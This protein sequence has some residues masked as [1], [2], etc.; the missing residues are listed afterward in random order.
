MTGARDAGLFVLLSALWGVA[1]VVIK[2][3]L[4]VLPPVLFAAFRYD[5]AGAVMLG[6]VAF[7]GDW[8]LRSRADYL[9][10][11]VGSTL[12]IGFYNALLFVGQSGVTS[13]VASILIAT[14]PILAAVFSRAL[15]GERL[16]A[17][18]AV[19][20]GLG[21]VGVGLVAAP[22]TLAVRELLSP[23]L[24]LA[25]AASVAL[26]SVLIQRLDAGIATEGLVAWSNALGAV[27][28]HAVSAALG[29]PVP[30][31]IT[32]EAVAAV[33]YLAVLASAA[34]YIVY[35]DLLDRLGAVEI[36][37]VSYAAPVFAV[38]VGWLALGE[39]IGPSTVVGFLA[40]FAG[41]AL[42][43]RRAFRERLPGVE[44]V[45]GSQTE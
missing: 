9:A 10:V 2:A 37:L 44:V 8:R 42:V 17:L 12:V 18:G 35:F 13:G 14:N 1:F 30:A 24:L 6:Y 4:A 20:L 28:L 21:L 32:A 5:V 34:G 38:V 29:E 7:T 23:A 3:G 25:A 22:E 39:R 16:S 26:G 33:A 41:F 19:G 11:L 31:S 15:L 45:S 40:I 27:V 36:N 43:K